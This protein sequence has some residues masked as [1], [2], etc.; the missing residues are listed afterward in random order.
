MIFAPTVLTETEERLRLEVREFLAAELPPDFRPGLGLG[1]GH[2]PE[3]S[4]RLAARGWVGMAIPREYG[5]QGATPVERFVVVEELLAAGAPIVA[6]W[7]AER[8]TAPTLLAFGTEEQRRWFLPRIA[9]GECWFSL[10][11][12]EPDAGSDLASVRTAATKVDGG[13][14]LNGT[15][16]WTSAAHLNHFFVVLCRTSPSDNRHGG[17]SQLIVDLH[18][19]GLKVSPIHYLDGGHHFNEVVFTDVFVSDDRVLGDVGSG[20]RQVTSE[21]A[22]E[23][24]GPDRYLSAFGLLAAFVREERQ[25]NEHQHREFGATFDD[26]ARAAVGRASAKLWTIRQLSLAVARSLEQGA[27]PAVEAALVKDIG[28]LYEQEVVEV[29][30]HVAGQEI[31]PGAPGLF[32]RLLAEAVQTAPSFTLRGGTTEVLRSIAAKGLTGAGR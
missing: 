23:R 22:Y 9:A 27:A 12:S 25:R 18:A 14:V 16:I 3:F 29:L 10:G 7:V 26:T 19:P 8:Q 4:R 11:M 24:S 2:D 6:H 15:K 32:E 20:W 30:R 5:G 28:T 1:G 13:W 31:D 21:L 17:L